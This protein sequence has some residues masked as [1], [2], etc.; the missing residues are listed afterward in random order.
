[1]LTP[2]FNHLNSPT[3]LLSLFSKLAQPNK[4]W[5]G[6]INQRAAAALSSG[7]TNPVIAMAT[8]TVSEPVR[9]SCRTQE[10][11]D[12]S[13]GPAP[14]S[15]LEGTTGDNA[16]DKP[17]SLV[18]G[19]G[20]IIPRWDVTPPGGRKLQYF[21]KTDT[22]P[23]T[24]KARF[25]AKEFQAAAD[26]WAKLQIGLTFSE[27]TNR[28]TANFYLVYRVNGLD[29]DGALAQAFFPH[30]F[31]QDVIVF[32][33]AFEGK[34]KSILKEIFLHEIGHVLGLRHEFAI[35]GDNLGNKPEG[36]GAKLFMEKN[37][38]S[39][40]SYNFPP[41][42]QDSDRTQTIEFYKLPLGYMVDGSPVTDYQP[43]IRRKN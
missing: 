12:P 31:D 14:V 33:Y 42:I 2:A 11:T 7:R 41:R 4:P 29:D 43:K 10:D 35:E 9:Y 5:C 1:L 24:D 22:F 13:W 6:N 16:P 34:N 19:Y 32:S 30:E 39:V 3:E 26:S 20:P 40:M 25:A 38:S 15:N 36:E 28:E 27:A 23:D 37:A 17:D 21:V 18:I 8:N